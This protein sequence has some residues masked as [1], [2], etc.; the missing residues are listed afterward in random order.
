MAKRNARQMREDLLLL[1][2]PTMLAFAERRMYVS[3]DVRVGETEQAR[4]ELMLRRVTREPDRFCEGHL[5]RL[6]S[7][8]N[9]PDEHAEHYRQTLAILD[10]MADSVAP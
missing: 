4:L 3:A 6:L 8:Q 2:G 5:Q 1:V 7:E 9:N 10:R